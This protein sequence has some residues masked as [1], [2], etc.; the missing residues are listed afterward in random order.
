M[1]SLRSRGS[2]WRYSDVAADR[3]TDRQTD[4]TT[5]ADRGGSSFVLATCWCLGEMGV[6]GGDVAA[7]HVINFY[8][9]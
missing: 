2:S 6:V 1:V 7:S 5:G 9:E 8:G 4:L 3:E